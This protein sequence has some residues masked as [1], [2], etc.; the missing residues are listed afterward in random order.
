[1]KRKIFICCSYL[2]VKKFLEKRFG[3]EHYFLERHAAL[4]KPEED[5]PIIK[6]LIQIGGFGELILAQ[7][8]DCIFFRDIVLRK[9]ELTF[10]QE[11]FLK[12]LYHKNMTEIEKEVKT[13]SKIGALYLAYLEH[14]HLELLKSPEFGDMIRYHQIEVKGMLTQVQ[15]GKSIEFNLNL[16]YQAV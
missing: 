12:E 10:P 7:D 15:K 16:A 4:L 9:N 3:S 2:L 8:L 13:S 6:D 1:M 5:I 14:L 11:D